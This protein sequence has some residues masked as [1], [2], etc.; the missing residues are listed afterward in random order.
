[1]YASSFVDAFPIWALYLI[2]AA[3]VLLSIEAG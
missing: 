3:A 1:M 2:T